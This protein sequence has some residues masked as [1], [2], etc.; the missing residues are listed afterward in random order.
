[1]AEP[2]DTIHLAATYV[3]AKPPNG[4]NIIG[5]GF[6]YDAPS[7]EF[8][9]HLEAV[10]AVVEWTN[11]VLNRAEEEIKKKNG[12]EIAGIDSDV[13]QNIKS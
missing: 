11:G 4:V 2:G 6:L 13:D 10:I 1:M 9:Q 7:V 5:G 12:A 3:G 8:A